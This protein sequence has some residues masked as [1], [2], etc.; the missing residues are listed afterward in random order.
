M[1]EL[2]AK[3]LSKG[4]GDILNLDLKSRMT[5]VEAKRLHR[6]ILL[7]LIIGIISPIL[8]ALPRA[9]DIQSGKTTHVH[10]GG[11]DFSIPN[12]YFRGPHK[13]EAESKRL[14]LWVMMPDYT[15]YSGEFE[16]TKDLRPVWLRH[17][18]VLIDDT[19]H[20]TDLKFQYNAARNG[21]GSAYDP[22]DVPDMFGF[23]RTLVYSN[24]KSSKPFINSEI[25]YS[26]NPD[27][28]IRAFAACEQDDPN[29][30]YSS[31]CRYSFQDGRLL[32]NLDYRKDNLIKSLA[33]ENDVRKLIESFS[34]VP[35]NQASQKEGIKLCPP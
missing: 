31:A 6:W 28:S 9:K 24:P 17:I 35:S 19:A 27:K 30:K 4:V 33:I 15:P 20:S 26:T 29:P 18:S 3:I 22:K 2:T 21:Y 16:H 34:C 13:Q 11:R 32:Y 25:Y 12:E 7:F 5:K 23:H 8:H 10:I 1:S 14:Y